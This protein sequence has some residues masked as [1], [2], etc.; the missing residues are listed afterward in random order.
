MMIFVFGSNLAGIHGAGAALT[1]YLLHGAKSGVGEGRTGNSYAIPT[2]RRDVRTSL[3][4][5]EVTKHILK[6]IFYAEDNPMES[7]QITRI[8]C[9]LAGFK[10]KDIAPLFNTCPQSNCFFDS[11]WQPYLDKGYQ[12]W[13][14]F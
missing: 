6:F 1:A 8:G 11:K 7:F 4:Q 12:Y 5:G 3:S 2:K 10:D 9:G 14:T 13:G